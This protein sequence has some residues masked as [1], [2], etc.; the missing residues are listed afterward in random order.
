[1]KIDT[2]YIDATRTVSETEGRVTIWLWLDVP[3]TEDGSVVPEHPVRLWV[4]LEWEKKAGGAESL[5][6][7]EENIPSE[8]LAVPA[9]ERRLKGRVKSLF[10]EAREI[11]FERGP[12]GTLDWAKE[13]MLSGRSARTETK[14]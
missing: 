6:V 14:E 12:S 5:K 8:W 11:M 9:Y 2:V 10:E 13:W 1:V 7:Y 3:R 4:E